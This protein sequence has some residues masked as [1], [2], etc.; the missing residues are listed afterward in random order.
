MGLQATMKGD[1]FMNL[2]LQIVEPSSKPQFLI[3][4]RSLTYARFLPLIRSLAL[5]HVLIPFPSL[6]PIL[7]A[8]L[9]ANTHLNRPRADSRVNAVV[10]QCGP[11]AQYY[12][13]QSNRNRLE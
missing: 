13:L 9:V 2:G 7:S 3:F 4:L 10:E 12:I 5:Y 8:G 6:S 11:V 1:Y